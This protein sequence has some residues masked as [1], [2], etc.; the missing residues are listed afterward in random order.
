[1]KSSV[2]ILA[3]ADLH[4]YLPVMPPCDLA[5]VCGDIFPVE[6]D[7]AVEVQGAW[8]RNV[9]MPWVEKIQGERVILIAGNHDYWIEENNQMLL[10]EFAPSAGRKLVYLCDRGMTFQGLQI[11]G[12]PWVP[13]PSRNKAFSKEEEQLREAYALIPPE[14]DLLL[15][16]TVPSGCNLD[17]TVYDKQ[18]W[19]SMALLKAVE[20]RQIRYLVGGH[21][22]APKHAMAQMVWG[23]HQTIMYNVACC[24]KHKNPIR[25]PTPITI[26]LT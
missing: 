25:L 7:R 10:T 24:D 18:L 21:I 9:F 22:H 6:M 1:M 5:V 4:G 11:Y 19:G 20:V 2:T 23:D 16:H 12:T 15:T 14:L 26:P 13:T 8:F 3:A 17:A